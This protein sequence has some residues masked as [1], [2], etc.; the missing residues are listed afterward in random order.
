MCI[1]SCGFFFFKF[2]V[3]FFTY[4]P[5]ILLTAPLPVTPAYNPFPLSSPS[6]LI[7]LLSFFECPSKYPPSL[8]LKIFA[9]P[10][11]SFSIEA[12]LEGYISHTGQ[13]FWDSPHSSCWR[14]T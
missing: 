14:P 12:Q 10:V 6:P 8:V 2:I 1:T 3:F 11:A 4:S 5:Y 13:S 7:F 9:R